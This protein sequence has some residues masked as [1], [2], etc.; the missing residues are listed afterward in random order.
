MKFFTRLEAYRFAG[1]DADFGAGSGIP[2]DASFAGADAEDAKSAQ[3]DAF[4]R[5]ESFF[6]TL[7][8]RIHRGLCL[9]ARQ[10]CA[11]DY[12]M[13]DVLLNQWSI[14]VG[15]SSLTVLRSAGFVPQILLRTRK[16]GNPGVSSLRGDGMRSCSL[17]QSIAQQNYL[18]QTIGVFRNMGYP[19]FQ[20]EPPVFFWRGKVYSGA[21]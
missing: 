6:Q 10:A 15:T 16:N 8:N 1:G 21:G 9:G 3:F 20:S 13:D 7:E 19:S 5:G 11:L 18:L 4:S 17:A 14:L 12:M 2:A